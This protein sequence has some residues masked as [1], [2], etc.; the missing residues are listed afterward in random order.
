MKTG[1]DVI[2]KQTCLKC[3]LKV[4]T[5]LKSLDHNLDMISAGPRHSFTI[6]QIFALS[7]IS[8]RQ[9]YP[10]TKSK[11]RTYRRTNGRMPAPIHNMSRFLNGQITTRTGFVF[12]LIFSRAEQNH[13]QYKKMFL[14]SY[15]SFSC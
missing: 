13:L 8:I 9:S 7:N 1:G 2:R 12:I 15:V 14:N 5:P 6:Y 4:V 11:Q 10:E 3:K